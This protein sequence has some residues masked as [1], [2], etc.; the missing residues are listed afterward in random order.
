MYFWPLPFNN[1]RLCKKNAKPDS[2]GEHTKT[3]GSLCHAAS[4]CTSYTLFS[5]G[6]SAEKVNSEDFVTSKNLVD[7]WH[8]LLLWYKV[9][10]S[11]TRIKSLNSSR[12]LVDAKI[13]PI[14]KSD[15]FMM[16]FDTA[17]QDKPDTSTGLA[18]PRFHIFWTLCDCITT[19]MLHSRRGFMFDLRTGKPFEIP[20]RDQFGRCRFVTEFEKLNRVRMPIS[21]TLAWHFGDLSLGCLL[22]EWCFLPGWWGHVWYCVQ[23]PRHQIWRGGCP[24]EDEDGERKGWN[25]GVWTP[26][27]IHPSWVSL[28]IEMACGHCRE[29]IIQSQ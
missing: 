14:E 27:N 29:T 23:S 26:G 3:K 9:H 17:G 4:L 16:N 20:E 25:A 10:I 24:Q 18:A 22:A 15:L 19:S 8:R 2:R 21:K 12:H 1:I 11:S 5:D 28:W 6:P 13:V 7:S